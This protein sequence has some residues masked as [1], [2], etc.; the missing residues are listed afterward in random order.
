MLV[1]WEEPSDLSVL[2]T[3]ALENRVFVIAAN[4]SFA[5][6]IGPDGAIL[7]CAS[8]ESRTPATAVIPLSEA[9]DK[10]IAPRTDL[11]VERRP[12]TYRF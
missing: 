1:F 11:L 6:I 3:R 2:R 8:A 5:A 9:A 12:A 4:S 7:S 10:S